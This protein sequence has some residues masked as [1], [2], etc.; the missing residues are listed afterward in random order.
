M[1]SQS[2][3]L[4]GDQKMSKSYQRVTC[5]KAKGA[6]YLYLPIL[7][8]GETNLIHT[9]TDQFIILCPDKHDFIFVKNFVDNDEQY[10]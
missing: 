7:E 8:R 1:K 2:N 9:E 3:E 10:V 4:A 5:P 6:A